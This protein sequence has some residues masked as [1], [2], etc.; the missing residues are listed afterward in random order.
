VLFGVG[1]FLKKHQKRYGSYYPFG[2]KLA[3]I[4]TQAAGK[5]IN[6][7][8]YNGK[9]QQNQEFSDG[10]GLEWYDYGAR[11]YDN[12]IGRW[13]TS[14]PKADLMRRWSPYNYA[15][16]NPIRFID[17]DGMGPDS[18]TSVNNVTIHQNSSTVYYKSSSATDTD[19]K[20][21]A[22]S[23]DENAQGQTS[24]KGGH[25]DING[26]KT[27]SKAKSSDDV[28]PKKVSYT[29]IPGGDAYK[30][31]QSAGVDIGD[32]AYSV[33]SAT[34]SATASI[35]G[36]V[37]PSNKIGENSVLANTDLG[38]KNANGN[39]GIDGKTVTTV[40][41]PGSREYFTNPDKAYGMFNTG[42]QIPNQGQIN[43]LTAFLVV[44]NLVSVV[45]AI[46]SV[47]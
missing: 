44:T 8:L 29:V 30:K 38:L 36:D 46:Q 25:E 3:G 40:I 6:K 10:S 14:D 15:F 37:G 33:N 28:D 43:K 23:G 47:N 16:D 26:N 41:F 27:F 32:V 34:K 17:P 24:L 5:L 13:M 35:V 9:E 39:N 1:R 31:L 20:G 19:G 42:G 2:G 7:F 11:M 45:S 18:L 22:K 4:S 12:Q 21:D